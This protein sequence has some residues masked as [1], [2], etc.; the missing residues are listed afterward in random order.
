MI[1]PNCRVGINLLNNNYVLVKLYLLIQL[2]LIKI[3]KTILRVCGRVSTL[4]DKRICP[5]SK[6]SK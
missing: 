2:Y 3:D 6:R 1:K 5:S 4:K